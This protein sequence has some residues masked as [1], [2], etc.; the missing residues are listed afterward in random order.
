M[1][2]KNYNLEMENIIKSFNG[3]KKSLML[4]SCC[5]P[6]SSGCLERL[7]ES[8]NITILYYNPNIDTEAEYN[9]RSKEQ[10]NLIE[11][12]E[13]SSEI[14]VIV[15]QYNNREFYDSVKGFE[16]CKEGGKRCEKCFRL[17]LEETAKEAKEMGFDYFTTTLSISP[18][19]NA[20]LL[21]KI[22][23]DISEKYDIK[24]LYSDFKKKN[25][26]K[27]SIELSEKYNMYRQDYCGCIYSKREME[28]KRLLSQ[29]N[30]K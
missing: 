19:K 12:M 17:R 14:N 9:L 28:E 23:E 13:L 1:N 5:G 29:N 16:K 7:D 18:Y 11:N 27:R 25:G 26:Y 3:E 2:K 20:E 6:C 10:I 30:E 8:F 22:G 4:H 24:Y 15:K 21:N